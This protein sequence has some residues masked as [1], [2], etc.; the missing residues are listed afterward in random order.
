MRAMVIT[1]KEGTYEKPSPGDKTKGGYRIRRKKLGYID[2]DL[3][4]NVVGTK[5]SC[6]HD[7][8]AMV[9]NIYGQNFKDDIY[10]DF[11]P[12]KYKYT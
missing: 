5:Q 10:K 12:H 7:F 4:S 3:D 6:I 8:F 1:N 9:G 11:P 2:F